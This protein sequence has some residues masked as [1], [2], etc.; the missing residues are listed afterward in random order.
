MKN[1]IGETIVAIFRKEWEKDEDEDEKSISTG[2]R[3]NERCKINKQVLSKS[4]DWK[5]VKGLIDYA[6]ATY[7]QSSVIK[8]L[9]E[10]RQKYRICKKELEELKQTFEKEVKFKVN[11]I[12]EKD[13]DEN[14]RN[15]VE[16]EI[17]IKVNELQ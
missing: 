14:M 10:M 12:I 11:E 17:E 7:N 16:Y 3:R 15:K 8:K 1:E 2:A 6:D 13:Y 5:Y 9:G 4:L